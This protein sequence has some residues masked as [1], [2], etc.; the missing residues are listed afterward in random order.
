MKGKLNVGLLKGGPDP[1]EM[2]GEHEG[3]GEAQC[4][5][6]NKQAQNVI[7]SGWPD[8]RLKRYVGSRL[9]NAHRILLSNASFNVGAAHWT[10]P[11]VG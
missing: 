7:C 2:A 5:W 8:T 1:S 9:L 11:S 4:G 6:I 10:A 3:L